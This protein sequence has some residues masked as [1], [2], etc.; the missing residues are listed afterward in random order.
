MKAKQ[1]TLGIL[2]ILAGAIVLFVNT[3]T[4][5]ARELAADW[6]PLTFIV[7]GLYML[8]VNARN[9]VWPIIL[10]LIGGVTLLRTLGI[11][12]VNLGTLIAPVILLGIGVSII[13]SAR[14][15]ANQGHN[16]TTEDSVT[17]ILGGSSSRNT[18]TAYTGGTVT[19]LMGGAE[20]DLSRATVKDHAVLRVNIV[21]GGL[22][23]RVADNVQIINRTQ[24][25]LGGIE[26]KTIPVAAN[27]ANPS[28]TIQGLVLM[29]GIEVKR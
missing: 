15:S 28:L 7:A 19:A 24:S 3:N 2:V 12:D 13:I 26:D 21:M 25:I 1:T 5:P 22:E 29:G 10:M 6:W 17:A 8:W 20:L 16:S 27:K 18:S 23:L 9:Y 11:A 14:G 4:G